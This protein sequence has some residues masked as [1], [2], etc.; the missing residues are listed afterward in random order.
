MKLFKVNGPTGPTETELN[1]VY[2]AVNLLTENEIED[3]LL[4]YFYTYIV[5]NDCINE[6]KR[7][8][9]KESFD[10]RIDNAFQLYFYE[11]KLLPVEFVDLIAKNM[12]DIV[13][14][15]W[16]D[17]VMATCVGIFKSRGYRKWKNGYD[18]SNLLTSMDSIAEKSI[19]Y[20][21]KKNKSC[22]EALR[23]LKNR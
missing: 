16:K 23:I 20:Q 2:D 1:T 13:P 8:E 4:M 15:E 22:K 14:C 7:L 21:L 5:F 18:L 6:I 17:E 9:M 10:R 19:T 11:K 3:F 12:N